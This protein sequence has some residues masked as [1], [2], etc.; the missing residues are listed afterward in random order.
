MTPI[1]ILLPRLDKLH[2]SNGKYHAR[3]PAHDDRN[4]SLSIREGSD[5][6]VLIH[7]H[8]GCDVAGI[9]ES[10]G[11]T[12]GDLF[13][14]DTRAKP[15]PREQDFEEEKIILRIAKNA[16]KQGLTLDPI[17]MNRVELAMHRVKTGKQLGII[18]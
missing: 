15:H 2:G 18:R 3:C 11:L 9:V 5:G 6:R 4:P 7:C 12:L 1:E 17:M 16:Y 14:D 13:P 10:L 8:A